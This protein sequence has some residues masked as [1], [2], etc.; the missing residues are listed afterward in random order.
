MNEEQKYYKVTAKCGHVGKNK[1]VKM[2]FYLRAESKKDAAQKVKKNPRVKKHH[3]DC[4]FAVDKIT[5]AEYWSGKKEFFEMEYNQ[6]KN[7]QEQ[8]LIM[9]RIAKDVYDETEW[10][11]DNRLSYDRDYRRLYYKEKYR[12]A[13]KERIR[14]KIKKNKAVLN[15]WNRE[16]KKEAIA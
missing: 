1:Y 11:I 4:I 13:R 2:D 10:Q 8:R 16:M 12:E 14:L 15:W 5:Y 6:A 7:I 9:D 3:K